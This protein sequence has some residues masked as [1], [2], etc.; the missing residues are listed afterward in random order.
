MIV[1]KKTVFTSII[2]SVLLSACASPPGRPLGAA[3]PTPVVLATEAD[4]AAIDAAT[5]LIQQGKHLDAAL[6]Y[7]RMA[8]KALPPTKQELQLN[9]AQAMLKGGYVVQAQQLVLDIDTST[10][11]DRIRIRK[12]LLLTE[13]DLSRGNAERGLKILEKILSVGDDPEL[14]LRYWSL[15][16]DAFA[17]VGNNLESARAR[18]QMLG[19]IDNFNDRAN[20]Q[21]ALLKALTTLSDDTLLRVSP[22]ASGDNIRTW[23]EL[24]LITRNY[25]RNSAEL[26]KR[27]NTWR[28]Q[29]PQLGLIENVVESLL[30][31]QKDKLDLPKRIALL[32]PFEGAFANVADAV[33]DGF[34]AAFYAN[35][36]ENYTPEVRI[37]DTGKVPDQI[38]STYLHAVQDGA[39]MVVG[40]LNKNAVN[41]LAGGSNLDVPVIALNYTDSQT[42]TPKSNFFQ[43]SLSPEDEAM[44]VAERAWLDQYQHPLILFPQGA[45]GE[46]VQA[47]FVERWQQLGGSVLE[48]IAYDPRNNDFSPAIRRVLNLDASQARR[49][50]LNQILNT[51]VEFTPRRRQDADF[52]FL[53]AFPRQARQI[54]PQ[55]RF[56]HAA[57]LPVYSTSHVYSGSVDANLDKDMDELR[58]GDM[59]WVLPQPR[60]LV[61]LKNTIEALWPSN[62]QGYAR[63]YAL[64]VDAFNIIP[65][66][67]QLI[68]IRTS[69]HDGETGQLYIDDANRIYRRISWVKFARGVP[70]ALDQQN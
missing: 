56:H 67:N 19:L 28:E 27:V 70:V 61:K 18:A 30:Y 63:F 40:P 55:L 36:I 57:D 69:S 29:N 1:K 2:F 45:W 16:A 6:I 8:A 52:I 42:T 58:F 65:H 35:K 68:S 48:S 14:R 34:L 39:Q 43:F 24:A 5:Q 4:N 59:P 54:S 12:L 49:V 17:L 46:R 10:V 62:G 7:S 23:M 15:K 13:I 11:T 51:K 25:Q 64:G 33:R 26:S 32:L 37:Y 44:Q 41:I 22:M 66:M 38:W 47:A 31:R 60:P 53:A 3:A 50:E 21:V 20:A 9:A